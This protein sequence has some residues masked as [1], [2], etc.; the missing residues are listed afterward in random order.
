M[1][2][3]VLS[4]LRESTLGKLQNLNFKR[5]LKFK[6]K[7]ELTMLSFN[8]DSQVMVDWGDSKSGSS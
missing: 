3:I 2:T 7:G 8:K 5:K 6:G 4:K 1:K